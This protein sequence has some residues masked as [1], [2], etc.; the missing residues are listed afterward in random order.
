[1]IKNYTILKCDKEATKLLFI[2]SD[3]NEE[4]AV[5][6]KYDYFPLKNDYFQ[7]HKIYRYDGDICL[8]NIPMFINISPCIWVNKIL[9]YDNNYIY[10][11]VLTSCDFIHDVKIFANYIRFM[12]HTMK[13]SK[14]NDK[15][16]LY[17]NIDLLNNYNVEI[18][19]D[20]LPSYLYKI[21]YILSNKKLMM[22]LYDYDNK[23]AKK[24]KYDDVIW[25]EYYKLEDEINK[26]Y[27]FH[28]DIS[29]FYS[30]RLIKNK[31]YDI[32]ICFRKWY[33]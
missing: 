30:N 11:Y 9:L 29:H 19:K 27:N 13:I 3:K 31:N 28:Y 5:Y 17:K 2:L 10:T 18:N 14:I 22:G 24:Y 1:M 26:K 16:I 15:K 25:D 4:M 32:K 8:I 12:F 33:L 21:S 23:Y 20:K 7:N 6:H